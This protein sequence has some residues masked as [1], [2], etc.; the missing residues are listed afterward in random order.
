[1]LESM[2][3]KIAMKYVLPAVR[4]KLALSCSGSINVSPSSPAPVTVCSWI[5]TQ[6]FSFMNSSTGV[7]RAGDALIQILTDSVPPLRC[8]LNCSRIRSFLAVMLNRIPFPALSPCS[9]D[10]SRLSAMVGAIELVG[11]GDAVGNCS[12][13]K[14]LISAYAGVASKLI[15]AIVMISFSSPSN[16]GSSYVPPSTSSASRKD[17]V[18]LPSPFVRLVI[19]TL[20][21]P[22][23]DCELN[24]S[25]VT[26]LNP[27]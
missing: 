13:V 8:N 6:S 16:S 7:V 12:S 18:P 10:V 21:T 3:V 27:T 14:T 5:S 4:D 23:F 2:P 22:S 19:M 25:A 17:S 24:P 9:G 11:A 15:S 1:M 26:R 20:L